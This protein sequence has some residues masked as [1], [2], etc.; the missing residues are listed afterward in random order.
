[1][2]RRER[3]FRF[4]NVDA[5]ME[6][7]HRHEMSEVSIL[8]EGLG[9]MLNPNDVFPKARRQDGEDDASK[10]DGTS[11]SE[12]SSDYDSQGDGS[13]VVDGSDCDGGE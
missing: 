12:G 9:R 10:S 4:R 13:E 7:H 5:L 6:W 3:E 8:S 1:M 11:R 2:E